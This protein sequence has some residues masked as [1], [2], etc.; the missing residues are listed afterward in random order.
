M[1]PP[2]F[3]SGN[4]LSSLRFN[5]ATAFR[6]WKPSTENRPQSWW[7]GFNG[8]TAFRQW[9]QPKPSRPPSTCWSFNGAT[10]FRQWKHF[11][12]TSRACAMSCFNGA[13][14]FRQWKRVQRIQQG[15]A[16]YVLQWGHRLSAVETGPLHL[17]CSVWPSS[18]NGAT[19]FRQ[20]KP[21]CSTPCRAPSP[22]FNGATAFRQLNPPQGQ[23]AG[24]IALL[25]S[26]GPPPF[27]SGN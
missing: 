20:W 15:I 6:Q 1:G 26:M 8:A 9:K 16:D 5:G 3:G 23:L 22:S 25:A 4:G 18:F 13:T 11:Y 24:I 10:A 2:P 21:W 17:G 7:P 27:G 12:G 19:A 14:T